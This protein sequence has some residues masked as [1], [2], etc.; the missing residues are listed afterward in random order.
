MPGVS[1]CC[2]SSPSSTSSVHSV[3]RIETR[4]PPDASKQQVVRGAQ[5]RHLLA[6]TASP[7]SVS[8]SLS[9]PCCRALSLRVSV[10][11]V[12]G[13]RWSLAC[14]VCCLPCSRRLPLPLPLALA[15][16]LRSW[17]A[18]RV[19]ESR[20]GSH[21]ACR[22][23]PRAAEIHCSIFPSYFFLSLSCFLSSSSPPPTPPPF[24]FPQLH[25][26]LLL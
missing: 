13:L 23:H 7:V 17:R 22:E 9:P 18:C 24:H 16:R 1:R 14:C 25:R 10:S 21:G 8:P 15:S 19:A 3:L 5:L 6:S 4:G 20:H 2:P 11:L 26:P 12:S